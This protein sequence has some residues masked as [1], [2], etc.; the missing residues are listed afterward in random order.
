MAWRPLTMG[1]GKREILF[2]SEFW[3]YPDMSN[4]SKLVHRPG[5]E[6]GTVDRNM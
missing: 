2:V 4:G 1:S 3:Q 6:Y 5:E